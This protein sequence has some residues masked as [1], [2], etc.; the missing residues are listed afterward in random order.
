MSAM[1]TY[2]IVASSSAANCHFIP[3]SWFKYKFI[4]MCIHHAIA[5]IEWSKYD[6]NDNVSTLRKTHSST[7]HI[8]FSVNGNQNDSNMVAI[9]SFDA[10]WFRSNHEDC[11][12][13]LYIVI[14]AYG[15]EKYK[16]NPHQLDRD[17]N[18]WIVENVDGK[19][20]TSLAYIIPC[21]LG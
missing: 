11:S 20:A 18:S 2:N 16:W 9:F 1:L 8:L 4:L 21:T 5:S 3:I 17:C 19:N 12:C 7:H 13:V 14:V 10:P 6:G 15:G